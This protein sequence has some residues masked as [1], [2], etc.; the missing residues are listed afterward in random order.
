[1]ECGSTG[2]RQFVHR[3][4]RRIA[5]PPWPGSSIEYSETQ[6]YECQEVGPHKQTTGHKLTPRVELVG[7]DRS[8][9]VLSIRDLRVSFVG[10]DGYLEALSGVSFDIF[11]GESVGLVGESGSGKT[12]TALAV[13]GLTDPSSTRTSGH[14]WFGNEDLLAMERTQLDCIRGNKIS[15]IFQHPMTSLNPVFRVGDQIRDVLRSHRSVSPRN[16]RRQILEML[17]AVGIS[18]PARRYNQ[19]PHELSGGLRQRVMIAMA[20]LCKPSLLIAD[21]PTTALDVTIQ[22]EIMELLRSMAKE[23]NLAVLLITHD[24]GVVA[25]MCDRLLVM[26]AGEIVE[27]GGLEVT[28]NRPL[29]PY[30]SAL[31]QSIPQ[32]TPRGESLRSLGGVVPSVGDYPEGCRFLPRCEHGQD[33]CAAPQDLRSGRAGN[34]GRCCRLNEFALPGLLGALGAAGD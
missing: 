28:L 8:D 15:M 20:L 13:L 21:E 22:A 33:E 12:L 27:E 30:T 7:E 3:W 26:Y 4:G 1:M 25:E 34:Q 16:S 5:A 6:G 31:L 18:D 10:R 32:A 17:E 19:Y 14:A 23:F 11:P 29:H 9:P 24:L 2:E